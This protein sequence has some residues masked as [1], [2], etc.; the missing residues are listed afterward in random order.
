MRGP[1]F[2]PRVERAC[3]CDGEAAHRC[4]VFLERRATTRS[5]QCFAVA[6]ARA[7]RVCAR[8]AWAGFRSARGTRGRAVCEP[9]RRRNVAS[10]ASQ[11]SVPET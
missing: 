8:R 7:S 11:R 1:V 5:T 9:L 4:A 6:A 3:R 2:G 10:T